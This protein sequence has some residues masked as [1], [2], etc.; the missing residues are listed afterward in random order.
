[1]N[2]EHCVSILTSQ[3]CLH[4]EAESTVQLVAWLCG[5][6]TML[7]QTQKKIVLASED[8]WPRYSVVTNVSAAVPRAQVHKQ[9]TASA[10]VKEM[11]EGCLFTSYENASNPVK[12]QLF[13]FYQPA[14]GQFGSIYW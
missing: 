1:A 5:L 10:A 8:G 6:D 14:M 7:T 11:T 12:R 9:Q 13:F 4:L 2:P 3:Q